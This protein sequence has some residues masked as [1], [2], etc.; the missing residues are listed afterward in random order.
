MKKNQAKKAPSTLP[1]YRVAAIQM[2]STPD[3]EYNLSL[4]KDL[5]N[6]ALKHDPSLVAFPENFLMFSANTQDLLKTAKKID[7]LIE[8]LQEWAAEEDIWL[9]AGSLP[10]ESSVKNKITNSS[11]LFSPE[12]SLHAHYDK[13]H[14]FD[15]DVKNDQSYRESKNVSPGK[16]P[17][18]AS[19]AWA[20]IGMS[21]CYDIRF[22]EL[23]RHYSKKGAQVLT[24]PSAFTDITGKA[25]WDLLTRTRAVENQCFVIAPAQWG[26]PYPGRKTYGHT[27][28]I[29]PWGR[30]L[31]ERNQGNGVVVADCDFNFQEQ[32]R[33]DLPCLKHRKLG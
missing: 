5:L 12:G 20:K 2:N 14:L 27:R 32:V 28:I 8:T 15:V 21:I 17:V 16:K 25:H 33:K 29:D 19:T 26:S 13:I 10:L 22:P 1:P 30:I 24:I 6:E 11:L 7:T 3:L 23:Y 9:L 18:L 4:A 31:A